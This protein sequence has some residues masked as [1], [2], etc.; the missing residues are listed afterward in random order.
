M[1]YKLDGG[2]DHIL[3]D[4]A[5]DTSPEQWK[6]VDA[7]HRGIFRGQGR[8]RAARTLFAVGDEKQSI[9]GFQGAEPESFERMRRSFQTRVENAAFPFEPKRLDLSFR[10]AAGIVEAVDEVFREPENFR[11]LSSGADETRTIHTAIRNDAPALVEVWD[12]VRVPEEKESELAWDAPLD[13]Q[14]SD[15]APGMLAGRI[16]KA[17][18]AWLTKPS[19]LIGDPVTEEPRPPH[20]GDIIVLVRSRG[21]LFEAILRE[22]KQSRNSRRGRRPPET[23]RAY[24]GDGHR[25]ALRRA[26]CFLPTISRSPAR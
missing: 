17:V 14:G 7:A 12:T 19:I 13:S 9:F 3:I 10:S 8:E 25:G 20:A 6:V 22:L 15:S 24:R 26:C 2:I 1:L 5:Q 11:G 23:F 18:N 21:P 16:A 4:E